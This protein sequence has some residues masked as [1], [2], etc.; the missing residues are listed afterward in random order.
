MDADDLQRKIYRGMDRA[1][2]HVGLKYSQVR[3]AS[4]TNPLAVSIGTIKAAFTPDGSYGK[5]QGYGKAVWRADTD[6]RKLEV[7]DYLIGDDTYFVVS[8]QPL[9]PIQAV[10]CNHTVNV[11]R[12][13]QQS[14][15]GAQPYGG[16]TKTTE[17]NLMT[18]GWPASVLQGTKG[19]KSEVNMPGDTR[20]PWWVILLPAYSGILIENADIVTDENNQRYV[21]SS[22]EQS[23]FGWRL[24]ASLA[25]T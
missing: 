2:R 10:K 24:T 7:G 16:T 3:P 6:G 20:T 19:E 5:P 18:G 21:V 9:L 25:V 13:A 11:T 15:I 1:A 8:M 14:G 23:E 22:A 17:I 12:P 4:A